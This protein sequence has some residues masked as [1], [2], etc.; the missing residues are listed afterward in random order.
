MWECFNQTW[1]HVTSALPCTLLCSAALKV[2]KQK[3]LKCLSCCLKGISLINLRCP[4]KPCSLT[5]AW[6]GSGSSRF[7]YIRTDSNP[8]GGCR[9]WLELLSVRLGFLQAHRMWSGLKTCCGA[10]TIVWIITYSCLTNT[11]PSVQEMKINKSGFTG[12][13]GKRILLNQFKHIDWM[14]FVYISHIADIKRSLW[15]RLILQKLD[16]IIGSF[17]KQQVAINRKQRLKQC[18]PFVSRLWA[19][20]EGATEVRKGKADSVFSLAGR[21]YIPPGVLHRQERQGKKRR[22]RMTCQ[23]QCCFV[24]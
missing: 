13:R 11:H 7:I 1:F 17:K 23:M 21:D 19:Q 16:V 24:C 4:Q 22:R 2:P 20:C 6:W 9:E 15:S 8:V 5:T 18:W 14:D 10:H 12:A 3:L